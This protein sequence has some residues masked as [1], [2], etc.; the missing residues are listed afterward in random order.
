MSRARIILVDPGT[1][2]G[3]QFVRD[4]SLDPGKV[5]LD[6]VWA[7]R[8]LEAGRALLEND[9]WGGLG[10]LDGSP[11][12][13]GDIEDEDKLEGPS[14]SRSNR[15]TAAKAKKPLA[16]LRDSP[17]NGVTSSASSSSLPTPRPTPSLHT[18]ISPQ[19]SQLQTMHSVTENSNREPH[20]HPTPPPIATYNP[21]AA[22]QYF[23]QQSPPP[24]TQ[25][26]QN[27]HNML[28]NP[29]MPPP[30]SIDLPPASQQFPNALQQ[31]GPNL[32]TISPELVQTFLL[33]QQQVSGFGG[34]NGMN[35]MN[36]IAGPQYP[37]NG[38]QSWP[39]IPQ[40]AATMLPPQ[41]YPPSMNP[42]QQ[43]FLPATAPEQQGRMT[44]PPLAIKSEPISVLPSITTKLDRMSPS[45]TIS[46]EERS[47]LTQTAKRRSSDTKL[48]SGR[49][50]KRSKRESEARSASVSNIAEPSSSSSAHKKRPSKH[51]PIELQFESPRRPDSSQRPST[52]GIFTDPDGEP[53][54]FFVQVDMRNRVAVT[55]MV[56]VRATY[57]LTSLIRALHSSIDAEKRRED[58]CAHRGSSIYHLDFPVKVD[59]SVA[60]G[61]EKAK[62]ACIAA[63]LR[64]SMRSRR[65][66]S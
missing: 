27:V 40:P 14:T 41:A 4:W 54:P 15:V 5:I 20:G 65:H 10:G 13:G 57:Q 37:F 36:M 58:Y 24:H 28:P 9:N 56:K 44:S 64:K 34:M 18:P 46:D 35:P 17:Q 66:H 19:V 47:I 53:M 7:Y 42:T 51:G 48:L 3:R 50:P 63:R 38:P 1:N 30:N 45:P 31:Y 12:D 8:S 2:E 29:P 62:T 6:Y 43:S 23:P 21:P 52:I 25:T 16:Q 39:G 55:S 26:H 22:P 59:K 33:W 61:G 60:Q 32:M 11:I 49:N